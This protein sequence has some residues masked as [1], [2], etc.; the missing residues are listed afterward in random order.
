MSVLYGKVRIYGESGQTITITDG[1]GNARTVQTTGQE[2][3]D[4]A[5]PGMEEY[6][7]A[8]E[9]ASETITLNL[10][11]FAEVTLPVG[12]PYYNE[13]KNGITLTEAQWLAFLDGGGIK[14]IIDNGETSTFLGKKVSLT[15]SAESTYTTWSIGDFNHDS[16]SNTCDLILD[17]TIHNTTFNTSQYYNNGTA[18]AWLIDTYYNGFSTNIK[19]K[20]QRMAIASNGITINDKVKLLSVTE[21]GGSHSYALVEGTKYPIFTSSSG[22]AADASRVRTGVNSTWW[23]RSRDTNN[24]NNVWRVAFEGSLSY[25]DH[26]NSHGLVPA[27]RFA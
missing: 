4:I 11:S 9:T 25:G 19:N 15:N 21:V 23:L 12:P 1:K 13:L 26:F 10:G 6:T 8:N 5:L 27:I 14:Y 20:L 18:R 22:V 16:T 24:T 3:T 7:I 17:N 2:F